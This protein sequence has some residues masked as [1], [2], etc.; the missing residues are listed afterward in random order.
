MATG[1]SKFKDNK[2]KVVAKVV[3]IEPIQN[4]ISPQPNPIEIFSSRILITR[5]ITYC[6]P[7]SILIILTSVNRAMNIVCDD[8]CYCVLL[9]IE[10]NYFWKTDQLLSNS[11]MTGNVQ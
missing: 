6:N 7:K 2:K 11:K 3:G 8:A 10:T 4:E 1:F 9:I 5:A